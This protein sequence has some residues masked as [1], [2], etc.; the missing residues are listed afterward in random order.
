L[1]F[2]AIIIGLVVGITV[3]FILSYLFAHLI[4]WAEARNPQLIGSKRIR[5]GEIAACSVM[6]LTC[7]VVAFL[8]ANL[9]LSQAR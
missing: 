8:V 6:F 4:I 9:L 1:Y 5:I 7:F 2:T 3:W